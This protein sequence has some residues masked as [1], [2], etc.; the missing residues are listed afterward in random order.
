MFV[1][2]LTRFLI[3]LSKKRRWVDSREDPRRK[4]RRQY[5]AALARNAKSRAE[6]RLCRRRT[7]GHHQFWLNDSQFRFQPGATGCS[8]AGI[9]LLMNPSFPAR[10]PLKMFHRVRDIYL[11]PINPSFLQRLIH[12]FSSRSNKGFASDIFVISRLLPDQHHGCALRAF[13]KNSLGRS[14]VQMTCSAMSCCFAYRGQ[15]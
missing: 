2:A 15:I 5:L 6:N 14:F 1:L 13:A 11:G 8:L 3:R 4:L 7:Q 10:L 9:W 12:D